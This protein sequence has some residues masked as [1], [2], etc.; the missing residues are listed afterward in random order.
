VVLRRRAALKRAKGALDALNAANKR[1][2]DNN[3]DTLNDD[4]EVNRS[5]VDASCIVDDVILQSEFEE[6][7]KTFG[8]RTKTASRLKIAV[9][10]LAFRIFV[11]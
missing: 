2:A 3:D 1:E 11:H 8:A 10:A 7:L 5:G 9:S 4:P 6:A